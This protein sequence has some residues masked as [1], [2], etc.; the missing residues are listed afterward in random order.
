MS[1]ILNRVTLAIGALVIAYSLL[2]NAVLLASQ[3]FVVYL[4]ASTASAFFDNAK[5]LR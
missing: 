5:F 2:E 1:G 4:P 3:M